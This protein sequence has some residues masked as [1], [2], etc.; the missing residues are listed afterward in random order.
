MKRSLV[1]ASSA[2]LLFAGVCTAQSEEKSKISDGAVKI[3][4]I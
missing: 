4:M 1:I 2:V 3:G